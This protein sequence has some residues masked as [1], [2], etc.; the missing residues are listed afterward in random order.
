MGVL[1]DSDILIEVTRGRNRSILTAWEVLGDSAEAVMC[2]PVSVAEL[3]H[4]ARPLEVDAITE[5]FDSLEVVN[6]DRETGRLA[7]EILKSCS[8]SH[9]VEI[10]DALIAAAVIVSGARLWTRNRKH[11]PMRALRFF[12]A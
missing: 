11:F 9:G 1:I 7:G 5:L 10:A 6:V 4:G 12:E 2:S 8:K 3:W